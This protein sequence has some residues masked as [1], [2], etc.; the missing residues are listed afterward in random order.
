MYEQIELFMEPESILDKM[1]EAYCE[2]S[3]SEHGFICGM[4]RK[5]RPHKIVEVGVAGGGTTAVIMKCLDLLHS[6]TRVYSVDLNE[7]CYRRSGKTTGYQLNEVKEELGNIS[8]HKFLLGQ[9]LPKVIDEIGGE[10]D[11]VILDTVHSMPGELLDFLCILPYLND[12]AIVVL[13][14]VILNLHDTSRKSLYATKIVL[15]AAVGR[16][17]FNYH[18]QVFN[19]GAIEIS[20]DTRTYAANLFSA[21]SITWT[22]LP[23]DMVFYRNIYK[24][25]YDAECVDLFDIFYEMQSGLLGRKHYFFVDVETLDNIYYLSEIEQN[26]EMLY[27]H[28]MDYNDEMIYILKSDGTIH[29]IVSR[30]D[31]YRHY[32]KNSKVLYINQKFSS[33]SSQDFLAAEKI[34]KK[35]NTIH[36]V[37]VVN[38]EKLMGVV[39]Y[40][41][42]KDRN[43]WEMYKRQLMRIKAIYRPMEQSQMV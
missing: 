42:T 40:K 16:K 36:E 4:I 35:Y 13:H 22:H 3:S 12:G 2:M 25:Y 6:D 20:Q 26:V 28:F 38:D 9:V 24:K 1:E 41:H 10:I 8:N 31:L 33:I 39:R 21:L 23:T 14:D 17:Y 27:R 19:I 11:F 15:D 7:E 43:D 5:Y 29:G 32:E 34:F 18:D 30:G 37:P